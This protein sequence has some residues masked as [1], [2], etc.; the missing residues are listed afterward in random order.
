MKPTGFDVEMAVLVTDE[1]R[2]PFFTGA[3]VI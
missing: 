1:G 3:S 2:N